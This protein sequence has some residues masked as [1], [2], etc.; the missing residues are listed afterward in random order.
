MAGLASVMGVTV[1]KFKGKSSEIDQLCS[2]LEKLLA[3]HR[4][5]FA[6]GLWTV[7]PVKKATICK[8]QNAL[9]MF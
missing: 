9:R 3:W 5:P 8:I 4:D 6:V 2:D 7:F 1:D